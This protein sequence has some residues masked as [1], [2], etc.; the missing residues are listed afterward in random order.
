VAA[1]D[2]ALETGS[3]Q[4]DNLQITVLPTLPIVTEVQIL[5]DLVRPIKIVSKI[6]SRPK[7]QQILP[8]VS[9]LY[10]FCGELRKS[11]VGELL[12]SLQTSNQITLHLVEVD[13]VRS[14]S[15]NMTAEGFW[16]S[17]VRRILQ[18]EFQV[19]IMTPPCS[20]FSRARNS[21][22]W[23]PPPV[24][25]KRF[26][27]G[28]PWLSGRHLQGVSIANLFI[29]QTFEGCQA[30][31]SVGAA[32]FLEHP[33]DLGTTDDLQ[34][35]ASL[36]AMEELLE[37]CRNTGARTA[38]FHQCHWGA[39]SSKP[40][41]TVSTLDLAADSTNVLFHAWPKFD[42]AGFYLGPLPRLCGHRHK[43]LL[44][45][46]ADG[47]AFKTSA[48]ASYP[49]AMCQ[50]IVSMIIRFCQR[51]EGGVQPSDNPDV[52]SS[53]P[54]SAPSSTGRSFPPLP[55]ASLM[56]E[57]SEEEEPGLVKQKLE[58]H[59]PGF[60]PP[61]K[62]VWAGK[63]RELHD[64][65]GLCSPGRWLPGRRKVCSWKGMEELGISLSKLL[66]QA[67]GEPAKVCLK[68]ACGQCKESPFADSLISA[69]RKLIAEAVAKESKFSSEQLL[70]VQENQP[71]LLRLIGETLRLMGDPDWR[72]YFESSRENFW[73][74][75]SVGP[76]TKMPR[77]PAVFERK[78]KFRSYDE[79]EFSADVANY[80][81]AAG[82][83]MAAVLEKQ[84]LEES[85]LGMMYRS[86]LSEAKDEWSDLRI[87]AQGAIEKSDDSWRI[88]HDAT[89][90][91]NI[92]NQTTIRDQL[93]MPSAADQRTV[94]QESAEHDEGPH[95]SLQFDVSKAHRRFLHKRKDW[96]YLCCRSDDKQEGLW[97]NRV[98]TFG[99]TCASYWW[100]RLAAGIARLV[101]RF[102]AQRWVIQLLFADDNRLQA[103][104]PQKFSDL[105]LGLFLWVLVG[106][107]LSWHKTK[108]GL[109]CEWIGFWIDYQRFEL[110]LSES[111]ALWLARWGQR[112][113]KDGLVQM[114]D[115][116]EGLGRLGF[117][118]GILEF[119]KP[120]LAPLYAWSAA[121]PLGAVLAVPPLVRLTL[122]WITAQLT[123]GKRMVS[124][125]KAAKDL[126]LLF[127]TDAKGEESFVVLGG[128]E[129]LP[130]HS[131]MQSRWFS[132][133]LTKDEVPWL[134]TRGH[135][136]RTIGAS[137]LLATM[138]AV[139]LFLPL[140][141]QLPAPTKGTVQCRGETDNQGNTYIVAK[142]MTTS[143]PLSAVLMQLTSMLGAR[144]LWLGL[145]WIPRESNE[146]AD[147]LTNDEFS[148]F[149]DSKRIAV[150]WSD[151]PLDVLEAL[152][153]EGESFLQEIAVHKENKKRAATLGSTPRKLRRK[154]KTP[155]GD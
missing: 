56:E 93:R 154:L 135:G 52:V 70:E 58:D 77:T 136:S 15:H 64:G 66:W 119:Y 149:D 61:L 142:M 155:W 9:V 72:I 7:L 115:F 109:S 23:G 32:F 41:R 97:I 124:C 68:L 123:S 2:L 134:F 45:R 101:I 152:L 10:V 146:E 81:S 6:I 26:P 76:G 71:F 51:P 37:L 100:G 118:A 47:S 78:T 133:T 14:D 108:G 21:N 112:V 116:A 4:H 62:A 40:T 95:F 92:N 11:D 5:Q 1:T 102:F 17:L 16:T 34:Q 80:K 73:D 67:L 19:I 153:Q 99:L 90:G 144:N 54:A 105:L 79:S 12:R 83:A 143:Y 128:W 129:C 122:S 28:Y 126:G 8:F 31:H 85:E 69:G 91:V 96:G 18:K 104:G 89:H 27:W 121:A 30:A 38:A 106:T 33:E 141:E 147:A 59:I 75:V 131:T 98:G 49:P 111:R 60:G 35:P 57:S 107:P 24:R 140:T 148:G 13:L 127:K 113:V 22:S 86:T 74:G 50:W 145:D 139:H 87:S 20:T 137:E 151:L 125:R 48:S 63:V 114:R 84:F 117:C 25:S 29:R 150:S 130:G 82:P 120:F 46:T 44:G 88:L 39:P 103:N 36:F 42:K 110:G 138:L 132:L 55:P 94:M 43:A 53:A 3:P 65:G